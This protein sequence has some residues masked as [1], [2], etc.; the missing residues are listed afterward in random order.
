MTAEPRGDPRID[1]LGPIID[2]QQLGRQV[3][4][5]QGSDVLTRNNNSVLRGGSLDGVGGDLAA[6]ADLPLGQ[7]GVQ[8]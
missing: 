4:H 6:A 7:P 1:V 3:G 8:P 5:D 2:R